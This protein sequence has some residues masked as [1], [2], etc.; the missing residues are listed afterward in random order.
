MSKK[1]NHY[2]ITKKELLNILVNIQVSGDV[3]ECINSLQPLQKLQQFRGRVEEYTG[4]YWIGQNS[5]NS[6]INSI[7]SK[8][9]KKIVITPWEKG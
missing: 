7:D 2:L 5:L 4:E 9:G 6:I 1:L 3:D 8:L